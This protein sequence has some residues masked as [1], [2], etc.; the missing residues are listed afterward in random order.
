MP[1]VGNRNTVFT[2]FTTSDANVTDD[3]TVTDDATIGG[4]LVSTGKIT[5]DAG[6]DIDN[7]NIDGTTIN[8]S[9]GDLTVSTAGDLIFST[10]GRDTKFSYAGT[11]EANLH[12]GTGSTVLSTIVSDRDLAFGGNDGGSTITALT[13]DMSDA[14][15]ATFNKGIKLDNGSGSALN[16][17]EEGLHTA[18]L[19]MGSGTAAL[20][21]NRMGYIKIGQSVT[22]FGELVVG[23]ISSPSGGTT[24][25]LPFATAVATGGA[26]GNRE[27]FCGQAIVSYNTPFSANNAPVLLANEHNVARCQIT[28]MADD[29]GFSAY[30]PATGD[31]FYISF[32]YATSV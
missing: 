27:H 29:S 7:I 13:F 9:S 16:D 18:T 31:T 22:V 8:L 20:S 12:T 17:Y 21:S 10:S 24:I 3:L 1:Y 14:G 5:A 32:T 15:M 11:H 23:S 19:T 26:T 28:Y 4:T 25:S 2:T 30:T 6:I